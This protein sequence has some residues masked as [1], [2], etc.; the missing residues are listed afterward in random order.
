MK[1]ILNDVKGRRL[2]VDQPSH[3]VDTLDWIRYMLIS[4]RSE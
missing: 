2:R 4:T 1:L 3:T